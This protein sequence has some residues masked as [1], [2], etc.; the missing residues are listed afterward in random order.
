MA[1]VVERVPHTM[2]RRF[3]S[4]ALLPAVVLLLTVR[5]QAGPPDDFPGH[6]PPGQFPETPP[7]PFPGHPPFQM[8]PLTSTPTP[9]PGG[10]PPP[11]Q[12]PLEPK[13]S[14]AVQFSFEA[15]PVGR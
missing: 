2:I 8:T 3:L 11:A 10:S 15:V 1:K 7:S 14:E 12:K 13:P 9:T 5:T 6:I 4:A